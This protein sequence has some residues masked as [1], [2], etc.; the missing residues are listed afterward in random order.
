MFND[1]GSRGRGALVAAI[2]FG[3]V[4]T[5]GAAR[6]GLYFRS[7]MLESG[8]FAVNALQVD[9]AK[10]FSEIYGN[11]SRFEFNHPGPAF[12]YVYAA[13]EY[14]LHDWLHLVPSPATAH[15]LGSL[16]LQCLFFALAIGVIHTH[17]PWRALAP[18]AL[19]AGAIYFGR[20]E[21]PFI[22]I[23]PPHV[24]L[25]PFLCFLAAG[26]SVGSGRFQDWPLVVVAGGFLFHGHVAQ[27]LFVGSLGGFALALSLGRLRP[28]AGE[29]W[30]D[31]VRRHRGRLV[32]CI[33][34]VFVFLAP[35]A[36]DV[37]TRGTRSNVATILG[38]FIGNTGEPISAFKSLLYFLSFGTSEQKQELL[39]AVLGPETRRFLADNA[40]QIAAWI[41]V[42][43]GP[44]LLAIRLRGSLSAAERRFFLTAG[45]FLA[46]A[47][48]ACLL[49]GKA[50]AGGMF[51]FNGH[52][53]YAIYYFGLLLALALAA[54][55]LERFRRAPW[56]VVVGLAAF[57]AARSFS[58]GPQS[59]NDAGLPLKRAVDA[60]IAADPDPR[61]KLLVFE[62]VRWHNVAAV[63]LELQ[64]RGVGFYVAPWWSFM[65]QSRHDLTRLGPAPEDRASIWWISA[66]S[67]DGLAIT[68]ELAIHWQP[69]A[70]GPGDVISLRSGANGFRF[71]V[72]GLAVGYGEF[73]ATNLPR[74]VFRF[75][76]QTTAHAVSVVFDAESDR[77]PL[78]QGADVFFN[79]EPVGRVAVGERESAAV[80][81]PVALWNRQPVATLE[82]R[83]P[84]AVPTRTY[85]RPDDEWWKAWNLWSIRFASDPASAT[86]PSP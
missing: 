17:L 13:A 74:A 27:S 56:V 41:A 11:Y 44:P 64:R 31:R 22:S 62:H 8:D 84:E 52:F 66:H 24:L 73:S 34:V 70:I 47:F 3:L 39:L 28:L 9:N 82:L 36:I 49:W 15:L 59:E 75:A 12:Y 43:A 53:Y 46:V 85:Q 51:Q 1:S 60:A 29:R 10:H 37:L 81:I 7:P 48:L 33:A 35:L 19:L 21:V 20:L 58:A 54:R 67:A 68:P 63:A 40:G 55:G 38:R 86:P 83:F 18:L 61:P 4:L 80:R 76:P 6:F 42:L 78:P 26:V 69:G 45:G 16:A 32:F 30:R 5:L 14:L 72:S 79:G 2:F 25:M 71:M 23:W 50:Q 77:R 65:F 57:L